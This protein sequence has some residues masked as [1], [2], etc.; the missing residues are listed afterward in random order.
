VNIKVDVL[1]GKVNYI[2][3]F[4]FIAN[5]GNLYIGMER[6][7]FKFHVKAVKLEIKG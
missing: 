7:V 5:I 2:T 6:H 1:V 4:I 3:S